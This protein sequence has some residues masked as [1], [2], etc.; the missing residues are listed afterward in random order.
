M[1]NRSFYENLMN[2]ERAGAPNRSPEAIARGVR[3]AREPALAAR[4]G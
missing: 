3:S 2:G 4:A 1:K